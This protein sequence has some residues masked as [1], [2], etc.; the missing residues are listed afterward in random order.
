MLVVVVVVRVLSCCSSECVGV[1]CWRTSVCVVVAA[2]GGA[3]VVFCVAFSFVGVRGRV[4]SDVVGYFL[5]RPKCCDGVQ[6]GNGVPSHTKC[7]SEVV[8]PGGISREVQ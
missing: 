6:R 3:E 5:E 8:G 4:R 2:V 1:S 7:Q